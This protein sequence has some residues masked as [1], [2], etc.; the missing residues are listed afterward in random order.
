MLPRWKISLRDIFW[1]MVLVAVVLVWWNARKELVHEFSTRTMRAMKTREPSQAS[2]KRRRWLQRLREMTT[3]QLL[4]GFHDFEPSER[5][6]PMYQCYLTEMARRKLAHNLQQAYD[7]IKSRPEQRQ[8]EGIERSLVLTALRE[9]QGKPA[10]LKITAKLTS[11]TGIQASVENVDF[12]GETVFFYE[13]G[14][15]G[16]TFDEGVPDRGGRRMNW[17]VHLI[18]QHGQRVPESNFDQVDYLANVAGNL[19]YVDLHSGDKVFCSDDLDA[20]RYV[21]PPPSG[22]YQLQLVL[23]FNE[24]RGE[25]DPEGFIVWKSEPMQVRVSNW[26]L[27]WRLVAIPAVLLGC[28]FV[29]SVAGYARICCGQPGFAWRD[30]F[31]LLLV[32]LFAVAWLGDNMWL[33]SNSREILNEGNAAWSMRATG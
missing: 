5:L 25:P 8:W 28:V 30:C 17:R 6:T 22:L 10:P 26:A 33:W 3:A 31:W 18:D 16:G 1:L 9:A 4:V 19:T 14:R 11:P 13:G 20:R 21:A 23:A 29:I 27:E 24:I 32:A 12:E 2:L 7:E 15:D